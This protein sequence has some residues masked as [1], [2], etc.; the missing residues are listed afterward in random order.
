MPKTIQRLLV[1]LLLATSSASAQLWETPQDT[2][3]QAIL[4][5]FTAQGN[6][7]TRSDKTDTKITL[8]VVA[9]TVVGVL[10]EA[11]TPADIARGIAAGWGIPEN[12]LTALTQNLSQPGLLSAA[13]KG[14]IE[15]S[16]DSATDLIALKVT[17]DGPTA[18]WL[19]YV[20]VRVWPDSAFPATKNV[21]GQAGAPNVLRI[22]S[23]FQCPYCKQMWDSSMQDWEKNT[24]QYRSY[25]YQFP[26]TRIHPNAQAA[27]E[28]SE[29]ASAQGKFWPFADTLFKEHANWVRLNAKDIPAK[30]TTYAKTA[31]LDTTAFNTCTAQHT[32]KA[33]V[34]AQEQAGI[35][36]GV[37]GTPTVY[38]NGIKLNDYSDADELARIRAVTTAK[39][40]AFDVIEGRLKL[41]R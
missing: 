34:D 40:G 22:F 24:A 4:K 3:K 31:G 11:R 33:S 29:C 9:G 5:A 13:R 18:K 14:F 16:D 32:Y 7:L 19:A 6:T 39:P 38:L 35:A 25:H 26:L 17:G 36:V 21:N 2:V 30:F 8:D 28:A 27:A 41:F 10:V 1:L 15:N 23:D 37:Q 20:A 12:K